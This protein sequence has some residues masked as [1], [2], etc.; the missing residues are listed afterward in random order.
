MINEAARAEVTEGV[1][2]L[3]Q[4][5]ALLAIVPAFAGL[6]SQALEALAGH[7]REEAYPAGSTLITEGDVG[8]R[9]YLIV[10][11]RVEVSAASAGASI[12]LHTLEE[13]ELFGEIAL[14]MPSLRR[15]ATVTALTDLLVLTLR[16]AEFEAFLAAYPAARSAFVA[17]AEITLTFKFLKQA[18]PFTTLDRSHLRWLAARIEHLVV[19]AGT[20]IIQQG[21]PG[22]TC[23]LLHSGRVEVLVREEGGAE[24]SLETHGPGRLFGE[25]ALLMDAPRNATVRALE[26]CE[27]LVL[28]RADLLEVMRAD[29]RT[30]ADII[31]LARL[32]DRPRQAPGILAYHRPTPEGEM[33]T[34]LKDPRR[35]VYY[36]LSPQGW[37]IWQRLDGSHN[38]RDLTLDYLAAF[39]AFA[40]QAISEV[41]YGLAAAGFA[42]GLRLRADVQESTSRVSA[43]EQ[44]VRLARRVLEWQISLH[45]VDRRVTSLYQAGLHRLYSWPAQLMLGVIALAGLIAFALTATQISATVL[46]TPGGVHLLWFLIPATLLSILIHEAGHAFTTKAFGHEV[47][48]AGIGWYWFAPMAFVDTSDMWLA[49]RWPRIAVSLAGPYTNLLLGSASALA[50]WLATNDVLTAALWQFALVSYSTVLFNLNPLLEFDGYYVLIDLLERPNLREQALTWLGSEL[51]K[52][53]RVPSMLRCHWVEVLYGSASLLYVVLIAILT[54]IAYRVLLQDWMARLLPAPLAIGLAWVLAVAAVILY[55]VVMISELRGLGGR[56]K[57]AL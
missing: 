1:V 2:P 30:N 38:L 45:N 20:T 54:V 4:R 29:A 32:R 48:R 52:A 44:M 8:D 23:Y 28:H 46:S 42:E 50:A 12:P 51:P 15:T 40:P 49:G 7:L 41:V 55:A 31:A 19:P 57:I 21:E 22:N 35:G 11:G 5:V 36:R 9:L 17:S 26:T 3:G 14:L 34:I 43:W 53:V 37:F 10:H 56:A 24:R 39:Q 33:I 25:A 27:L 18:S 13:G 16:A 6:S 47:P